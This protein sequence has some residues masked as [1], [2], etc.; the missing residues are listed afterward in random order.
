MYTHTTT[1]YGTD[2]VT[3][4]LINWRAV[5]GGAVIGIGILALLS[6]LWLALAFSSNVTFIRD[7]MEWFLGG[8]G[9]FALFVA[10]Y[11]AGAISGARG[12]AAGFVQALTLWALVVIAALA[13]AVPSAL[14]LLNINLV[15]TN[16]VNT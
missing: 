14:R 16:G 8:T 6:A 10:G 2:E 15:P 13:V 9:I 1:V 7:N 4:T 12:V 5:F 3:P 11:M